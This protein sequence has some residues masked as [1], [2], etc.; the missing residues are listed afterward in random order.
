MREAFGQIQAIVAKLKPRNDDDFI[1][2]LHYIITPSILFTFSFI[3][4]AKQFVGQP[5]QC[6]APAEFKRQWSRYAEGLCFVENTY[7]VGMDERFPMRPI[8]RERREIHYYQWVPFI[9][10][11]EALLMML[12]K[13]LWNAFNWKSGLDIRSLVQRAKK[14]SE[15][16]EYEGKIKASQD[17]EERLAIGL[18]Q[19]KYR[20]MTKT[21]RGGIIQECPETLNGPWA[22]AT[23][24]TGCYLALKLL[25]F[26]SILLQLYVLTLFL[27][28]A[29]E[30]GKESFWGFV[31]VNDLLNGRDWHKSGAFPR[32]TYC[33]FEIRQAA[34]EMR[35]MQFSLQCVL[36]INMINEK[37]FLFIWFWLIALAV[38][39]TFNLLYWFYQAFCVTSA[40]RFV[41]SQ[42]RLSIAN[43]PSNKEIR[44][45]V[46][47]GLSYDG[48]TVLRLIALNC[49]PTICSLLVR[50]LW[51]RFEQSF[52]SGQR[53]VGEQI[54]NNNGNANNQNYSTCEK[55]KF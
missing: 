34:R 23:F 24:V 41:R 39:G 26:A 43:M 50:Y 18:K 21:G 48:I 53:N 7:F 13:L 6:W 28:N 46:R 25:N 36:M 17:L 10:V 9:L 8:E 38:I 12:P 11:G 27:G 29:N 3:V 1:D 20:N 16:G 2:R 51:E 30:S 44:E 32:V 31:V 45:F 35:P 19:A 14:L 4:G 15:S 52:L 54:N 22:S 49:D 5:I 42:L 55:K 47:V 33:D 37:I 40:D